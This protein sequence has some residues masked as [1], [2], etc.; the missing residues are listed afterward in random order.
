M[1]QLARFSGLVVL[2]LGA[3]TVSNKIAALTP[4][5]DETADIAHRMRVK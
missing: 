3:P 1:T 2:R 5:F 4:F